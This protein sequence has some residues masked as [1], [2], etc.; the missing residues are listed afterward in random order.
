MI[1]YIWYL[2]I[3]CLAIF[4]IT[5]LIITFDLIYFLCKI[6]SYITIVV[7]LIATF[8]YINNNYAKDFVKN[9]YYYYDITNYTAYLQSIKNIDI[10][11]NIKAK[12]LNFF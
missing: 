3:F 5:I 4:C 10:P 11:I 8:I 12:F 6:I 7:I 2:Y 1:E 9:N